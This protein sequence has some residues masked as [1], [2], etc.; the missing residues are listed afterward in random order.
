MLINNDYLIIIETDVYNSASNLPLVSIPYPA[1]MP[2]GPA[3]INIAIISLKKIY[4]YIY[5][6][7]VK[8][9]CKKYH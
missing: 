7:G 8:Y 9:I 4:I 5:I 1:R 6:G 2:D 3:N